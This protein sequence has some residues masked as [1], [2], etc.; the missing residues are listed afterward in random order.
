M[1][2]LVLDMAY[3]PMERVSW[4]KA[5]ELIVREK[6]TVL[7]EYADRFINGACKVFAMPSV[8]VKKTIR[9]TKRTVKFSKKN[10]FLRDRGTCQYCTEK[11]A[12]SKAT[13]DHVLP[14][15]RGGITTWDNIVIA[16][17]PCNQMKS[18]KTPQEANM[19]LHKPPRRPKFLEIY[20][21]PTFDGEIPDD[22]KFFLG[23]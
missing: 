3:Q 7:A 23:V 10:V 5:F 4:R 9:K 20:E 21:R 18:N 8:I 14:K 11:I 22:W 16:C 15:S 2:T 1:D 19:L 13:F 12:I 6:A 17:R